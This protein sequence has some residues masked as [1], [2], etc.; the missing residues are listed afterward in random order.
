MKRFFP[1]FFLI[2][3]AALVVVWW[4]TRPTFLT[5]S[6]TV[7]IEHGANLANGEL[8]FNAGGCA[9]CHMTPGQ[10]DRKKLGGGLALKTEFGTFI[11]PNISSHKTDGIGAW[12][13]L[14]L[15]NA[16]QRGVSP[17]GEHY[18]PAFPYT[19]YAHA[20]V[21]DIRDLKAYLASLPAVAG[22]APDHDLKFPFS[23]RRLVGLWKVLF[24][25]TALIQ[26]DLSKSE[27]WNR[28]H[29]L[30]DAL[31]HCA[32]CHSPRNFLGGIVQAQRYA[33]GPDAEGRG[34]VPNITAKGLGSWSKADVS[35]L[36]ASGFTPE[37]DSVGSSM[38]DVV[39]N[40]A[41]L[42]KSDRDAMA[43]YLKS[44]PAVDGP[45]KP[46]KK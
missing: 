20:N 17:Q 42:P 11:A 37:F 35:D 43:E 2:I 46:P 7:G 16:M 36:L 14:N 27:A 26:E 45:P 1:D 44:L 41:A 31:G 34:W 32:E 18:Y 10:E 6:E 29:Y 12:S 4:M 40:M 24:L 28:G 38:A 33:G 3:V 21:D 13:A 9:S 19:T 22:K 15:A 23:I 30:A 8:V 39:K 25:D 5:G